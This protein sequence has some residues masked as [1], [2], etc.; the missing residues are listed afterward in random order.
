MLTVK[1]IS[2]KI[3]DK[4]ILKNVSFN[5]DFGSICGLLGPNGAGKTSSFYI[6]AGLS[7]QTKATFN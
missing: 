2:K 6:I 4:K 5:V 1:D 7:I 3:K